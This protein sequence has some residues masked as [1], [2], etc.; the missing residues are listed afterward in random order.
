MIKLTD[1]LIK[2]SFFKIGIDSTY[3]DVYDAE[4]RKCFKELQNG[5]PNTERKSE[6]ES[7]VM[8]SLRFAKEYVE[9]YEKERRKG[10]GKEWSESYARNIDIET[11]DNTVFLAMNAVTDDKERERELEIHAN[12]LNTDPVFKERYKNL[13]IEGCR[14]AEGK[15]NH[16]S[17]VYYEC[18]KKGKSDIYA[19]AF[20][21]VE[22]RFTEKYCEIYA[23][24]YEESYN[25]NEDAFQSACFADFCTDAVDQGVFSM[26]FE[27]KKRFT[28]AWQIDFYIQLMCDDYAEI[29]G[30]Q[31]SENDYRSL[32]KDFQKEFNVC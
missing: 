6:D 1:S 20:A 21:S 5:E 14:E 22:P 4:V 11:E 3:F 17:Q 32:K 30:I 9:C 12:T 10:H 8:V 16:F 29:E 28:E 26:C 7:I 2:E 31:L 24:A 19:K 23:L 27:F 15:A 18:V 25:H 13:I